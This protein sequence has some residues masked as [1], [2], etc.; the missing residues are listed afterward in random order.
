MEMRFVLFCAVVALLA[1]A[2]PA[3][4]VVADY[5]ANFASPTPATGWSYRWNAT[6]VP[7]FSDPSNFIGNPA[8]YAALSYNST[9]SAY[10]TLSTGS[11]PQ[12][13]PGSF[14]SASPTYVTLGQSGTQAA[15]GNSH[16][17]ILAYTFSS[18]QVAAD[19]PTTV[20]GGDTIYIALGATGNYSGQQI[21]VSYTLGLAPEPAE[22]SLL[23][24]IPLM[25]RRRRA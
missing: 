21:G 13:A 14:L 3:V 1:A 9:G 11:L 6:N 19:G 12:A 23:A 2:S 7:L 4:T 5:Q 24:L 22:L 16:Y 25:A 15:D 10:E 20:A 18:A 17:V 8:N